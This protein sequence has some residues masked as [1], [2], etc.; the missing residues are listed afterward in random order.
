MEIEM[1]FTIQSALDLS[2]PVGTRTGDD[3]ETILVFR[4]PYTGS[5]AWKDAEKSMPEY[6]CPEYRW[7]KGFSGT[8][9]FELKRPADDPNW[10]RLGT[11]NIYDHSGSNT[12]YEKPPRDYEVTCEAWDSDDERWVNTNET[13]RSQ[14]FLIS[15]LLIAL[16]PGDFLSEGARSG[17]FRTWNTSIEIVG[18]PITCSQGCFDDNPC[19]DNDRCELGVGCAHDML[20]GQFDFDPHDC[21][22]NECYNGYAAD[23]PDDSEIPRQ[24]GPPDDCMKDV[25]SGGTVAT[26]PAPHPEEIPPNEPGNCRRE[27]CGLYDVIYWTDNTDLPPQDS[28]NDCVRETCQLGEPIS[29]PDDSETPLPAPDGSPRVCRNGTAVPL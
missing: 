28:P 10:L 16:I 2:T 5:V 7:S 11:F 9:T 26:V 23:I 15:Q 13:R 18:S 20:N 22:K 12:P 3:G 21:Y 24:S 29:V 6:R 8:G 19:T 14:D 4:A 1:S 27:E 17:G 25:C